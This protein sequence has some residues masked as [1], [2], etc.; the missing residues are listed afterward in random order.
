M[1]EAI[2]SYDLIQD[3]KFLEVH[4]QMETLKE[5][6]TRLAKDQAEMRDTIKFLDEKSK[7]L[8]RVLGICQR[9][10]VTRTELDAE[11][12][13]CERELH[14][15]KRGTAVEATRTAIYAAACEWLGQ[16]FKP[17]DWS[18]AG[19]DHGTSWTLV[20]KGQQGLAA[21]AAHQENLVLRKA[22]G[23]WGKLF[24]ETT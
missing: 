18:L 7:E 19:P 6:H 11:Q 3:C 20:F 16:R 2:R 1:G 4:G 21:R 22:S 17:E 24:V 9:Q 12:W 13:A 15:L 14:V 8:E 23:D 5:S 10:E